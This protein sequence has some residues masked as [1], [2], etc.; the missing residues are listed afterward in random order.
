MKKRVEKWLIKKGVELLCDNIRSQTIARLFPSIDTV[1][2]LN[3]L[4][5]AARQTVREI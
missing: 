1:D 4:S 2:F 3:N 5:E